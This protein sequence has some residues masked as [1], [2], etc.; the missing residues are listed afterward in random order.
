M[1]FCF[2]GR[3]R[4]IKL[5]K[6]SG[7]IN[8]GGLIPISGLLL[9]LLILISNSYSISQNRLVKAI[10]ELPPDIKQ[11]IREQEE[12]RRQ[13][14]NVGAEDKISEQNSLFKQQLEQLGRKAGLSDTSTPTEV[15]K[16]IKNIEEALTS[17]KKQREKIKAGLRRFAEGSPQRTQLIKEIQA[18]NERLSYFDSVKEGLKAARGRK[19]ADI[20]EELGKAIRRAK[21]YGDY[22]D[23]G[24]KR[25]MELLEERRQLL[26]LRSSKPVTPPVG[27][28]TITPAQR[29]KE[30]IK[31][32]A[33]KLTEANKR[34]EGF[35]DIAE[36]LE[37][38][39]AKFKG[40]ISAKELEQLEEARKTAVELKILKSINPSSPNLT[41]LFSRL[42]SLLIGLTIA[43]PLFFVSDLF[44][45]QPLILPK[46]K[47]TEG[48]IKYTS[49]SWSSIR[50]L[51]Q[52]L[53]EERV[54]KNSKQ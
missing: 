12:R 8:K 20:I 24:F 50:K 40:K 26:G 9:L 25:V 21:Q 45:D 42:R 37:A 10:E 33:E 35:A 31:K 41:R 17:L 32:I 19:A 16:R 53:E 6:P 46:P 11:L 52:Q 43:L 27:E 29:A 1:D 14:R 18:T 3:A 47:K 38:T 4:T 34:P 51:K 15:E 39:I 28:E 22:T 49:P 2:K 48:P 7:G 13:L 5:I 54:G 23:E 44:A 36:E 30:E